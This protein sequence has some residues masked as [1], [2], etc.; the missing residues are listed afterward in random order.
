[1]ANGRY[2]GGCLLERGSKHT[3]ETRLVAWVEDGITKL[4]RARRVQVRLKDGI[5][6]LDK[7][8]GST[9]VVDEGDEVM[10]RVEGIFP[11]GGFVVGVTPITAAARERILVDEGAIR[12]SGND[13]AGVI[14]GRGC[15]VVVVAPI[16]RTIE[17]LCCVGRVTKSGRDLV[18]TKVIGRVFDST[19][20]GTCISRCDVI[21]S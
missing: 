14:Q 19:R 4:R 5:E 12:V 16:A 13:K 15:R 20:Y 8:F 6:F 10:V 2:K 9:G 17:V 1:M 7:L 21:I 11:W 3:G 18:E